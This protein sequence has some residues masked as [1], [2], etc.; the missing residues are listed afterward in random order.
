M[1]CSSSS[2][3]PSLLDGIQFTS[4]KLAGL[5][6]ART[7]KRFLLLHENG[8]RRRTLRLWQG[9]GDGAFPAWLQLLKD[10]VCSRPPPRRLAVLRLGR[11]AGSV[12]MAGHVP[13]TSK[14][15]NTAQTVSSDDEDDVSSTEEQLATGNLNA[16]AARKF[17]TALL[18]EDPRWAHLASTFSLERVAKRTPAQRTRW[19]SL[20]YSGD[21]RVWYEP[22]LW[23]GDEAVAAD[24][25][26]YN[27]C[28]AFDCLSP[29]RFAQ[30]PLVL[31]NAW[32]RLLGE[33]GRRHLLLHFLLMN[34]LSVRRDACFSRRGHG[35]PWARTCLP[36]GRDDEAK[37][38]FLGTTQLLG[39]LTR[40]DGPWCELR[41][42]RPRHGALCVD[43]R[44]RPHGSAARVCFNQER[45]LVALLRA[46]PTQ[47]VAADLPQLTDSQRSATKV[48]VG[49][50]GAAGRNGRDGKNHYRVRGVAYGHGG[51]VRGHDAQRRAQRAPARRRRVAT[52]RNLRR[53][54]HFFPGLQD[55][56]VALHPRAVRTPTTVRYALIVDEVSLMSPAFLLQLLLA[57]RRLAPNIVRVPPL[58]CC[59]VAPAAAYC[60]NTLK[61][62][63]DT[64]RPTSLLCAASDS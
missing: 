28:D 3:A 60:S 27:L 25:G 44:R 19:L 32:V 39:R 41:A 5:Q 6:R 4:W 61:Y 30:L 56:R 42:Y 26:A 62:K 59:G 55:A 54:R 18:L 49:R 34:T 33:H 14:R 58:L 13:P 12:V 53:R 64:S 31:R 46:V 29:R 22:K 57:L 8:G 50:R 11:P 1:A 35:V 17:L 20:Y 38:C 10:S 40:S 24:Y 48:P 23:L 9:K 43:P 63:S 47:P 2:S 21:P 37:M 7:G 51:A 52:C 45:Q 16:A 15:K 36:L